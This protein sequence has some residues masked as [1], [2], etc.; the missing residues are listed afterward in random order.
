MAWQVKTF[1][2]Q[3]VEVP[4]LSTHALFTKEYESEQAVANPVELEHDTTPVVVVKQ[5]TH[6][7]S[8]LE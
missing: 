3:F 1:C 6:G 2:P 7:T 5:E 4:L 8:P